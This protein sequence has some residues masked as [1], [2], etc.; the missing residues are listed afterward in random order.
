MKVAAINDM[1]GFGKCSLIADISV[2]SS[3]GIEVCPVPTAIFTAQTGFPSYHMRDMTDDIPFFTY[4]WKK[5]KENFDGI[6]TGYML[7]EKEAD[8][9]IEFVKNFYREDN[10][11]LVDPVMGDGGRGYSNFSQ[12]FLK[13]IKELAS[14]ADILTPNLTELCFLAGGGARELV[15]EKDE[16]RLISKVIELADTIGKKEQAA[17]IVTGLP[18]QGE[19]EIGNLVI[20]DGNAELVR[21]QSNEKSYSGTGDLFA[22]SLLGNIL[23]GKMIM[24]S[25]LLSAEFISKAIAVTG[26]RNRSY[27]VDYELILKGEKYE[28]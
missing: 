19:G 10:I 2:L 23:N 5:M 27:G 9:V 6:L 20:I 24:Q 1:S 14:M 7:N 11:L 16:K 22:A 3:M 28:Q 8:H 4:E 17:V 25:V 13:K 26:S 18:L 21:S 12:E 15:E